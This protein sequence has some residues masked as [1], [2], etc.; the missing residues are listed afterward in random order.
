M[1]NYVTHVLYEVCALENSSL[2][3]DELNKLYKVT[4]YIY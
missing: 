2:F 3:S 4:I 1:L